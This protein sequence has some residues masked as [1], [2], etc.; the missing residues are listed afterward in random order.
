MRPTNH[1]QPEEI[2]RQTLAA[3]SMPTLRLA[4]GQEHETWEQVRT[5]D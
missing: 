2:A 5:D 3:E 1:P 4:E